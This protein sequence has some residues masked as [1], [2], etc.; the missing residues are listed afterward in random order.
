ML[1]VCP[2][3]A[4]L[5]SEAASFFSVDGGSCLSWPSK[6]DADFAMVSR[7]VIRNKMTV[8]LAAGRQMI[9]S[10]FHLLKNLPPLYVWSYYHNRAAISKRD[11][12]CLSQTYCRESSSQ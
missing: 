8:T 3:G 12:L 11:L 5:D 4:A 10:I 7:E 2:A 9:L 1:R 6:A